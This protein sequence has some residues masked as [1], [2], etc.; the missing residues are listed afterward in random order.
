[1][2]R[3]GGSQRDAALRAYH[4]AQIIEMSVL[5][6]LPQRDIARTLGIS[7]QAVSI[8]LRLLKEEWRAQA[9]EDLQVVLATEL[10]R[11]DMVQ[12]EYW[13]AWKSRQQ[14][15]VTVSRQGADG[16]KLSPAST[17]DP[18]PSTGS[19]DSTGTDEGA[20]IGSAPISPSPEPDPALPALPAGAHI[21]TVTHKRKRRNGDPSFLRGVQR[22]IAMRL[23][24]LGLDHRQPAPV[25]VTA[26]TAYDRSDAASEGSPGPQ[27]PVVC[28]RLIHAGLTQFNANK[29]T[30]QHAAR[31]EP[32]PLTAI[33]C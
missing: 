27:R 4:R 19:A 22:C 6:H 31:Q 7:Q 28:G 25:P 18:L 17:V 21:V 2:G 1:M 23:R 12:Y 20:A 24:L 3:S 5:Q 15:M 32:R 10:A 11:L 9:D 29:V 33:Y 8:E 14:D 30:H 26:S 16:S 13:L